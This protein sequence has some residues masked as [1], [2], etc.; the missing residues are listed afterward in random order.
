MWCFLSK[1]FCKH[2]YFCKGNPWVCTTICGYGRLVW[3]EAK[4]GHSDDANT[5]KG[6]GCENCSTKNNYIFYILF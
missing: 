5:N 1:L 3:I 6:D 2:G 4:S